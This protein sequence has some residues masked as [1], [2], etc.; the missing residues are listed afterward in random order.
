MSDVAAAIRAKLTGE[1]SNEACLG[2]CGT[3]DCRCT[4]YGFDEMRDALLAV[5]DAC[6]PDALPPNGCGCDGDLK[7]WILHQ[8]AKALE[9]QEDG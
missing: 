5:L 3:E 9:I 4:V 2:G 7:Q 8:V 1:Y 6:A